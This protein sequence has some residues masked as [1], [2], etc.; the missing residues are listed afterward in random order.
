M[1]AMSTRRLVIAAGL[2][3]LTFSTT[4]AQVKMEREYRLK[5]GQ[6]P[7]P[8]T[9][10][11]SSLGEL[12]RLRWYREESLDGISVEAKFLLDGRKY[13]IEFDTSGRLQDV[14]FI[15]PAAR[16]PSPALERLKTGLD[17]HFSNWKFS[18]VQR[19]H[20]GEPDLHRLYI[21]ENVLAKGLELFYEVELRGEKN[22]VA[23]LYEVKADRDGSILAVK[24]ILPKA[25]EHLEY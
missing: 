20:Q 25:A 21:M 8:A 4:R 11:I 22:G 16:I 17:S 5:E 1:S 3:L 14:E 10:F 24:H 9:D 12:T 13:S 23:G 15:I 19:Q 7:A 18:K 6:V 2:F